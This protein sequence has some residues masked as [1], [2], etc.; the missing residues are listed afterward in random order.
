MTKSNV[1]K[2]PMPGTIVK[3]FVKPGQEVKEG[4]PVISIES[5]KMEFM[6]K[7]THSATVQ[8]IRTSEGKFANMGEVLVT[9]NE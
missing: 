1:V 8:E 3:V 5:M 6:V 7:A 9:Y 2:S 4:D